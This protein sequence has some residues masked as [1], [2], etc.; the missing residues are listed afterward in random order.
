MAKALQIAAAFERIA[1]VET[2]QG[3]AGAQLMKLLYY[4]QAITLAE[5]G[6]PLFEGRFESWTHGPV[7]PAVWTFMQQNATD[8]RWRLHGEEPQMSDDIWERLRGVYRVFGVLNAAELSL[9]TRAERPWL[10]AHEGV[11]WADASREP[12]GDAVIRDFYA[13]LLGDG[14]DAAQ[15][16]GLKSEQD[17]PAWSIP[18]HLGVNLK[19]LSGH[20]FFDD[21]TSRQWRVALGLG[22]VPD[23]WS[24]NDFRPLERT[25]RELRAPST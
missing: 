18:Y 16:L 12:I 21:A 5:T 22:E 19:R 4:T 14:E 8:W 20:P 11:K 23:Q 9:A 13:E 6:A 2:G 7:E 1:E 24:E 17:S 10:R 15:E 3:L 25:A